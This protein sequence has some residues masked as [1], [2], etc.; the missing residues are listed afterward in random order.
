MR[1]PTFLFAALCGLF[2]SAGCNAD[3][4]Y[5]PE[6]IGQEGRVTV[7]IDSSQWSAEVGEALRD[8]LGSDIATLPAP[9]PAFDLRQA[10]I[11]SPDQFEELQKFKNIIFVG[12][13]SD[14]TRE[15]QFLRSVFSPEAQTAIQDGNTALVGRR[16]V[17]R[18]RQQVFYLTADTPSALANAIREDG[19]AI[20]DTFE[21]VTRERLYREMFERGRQPDLEEQ[22]MEQY[23]FAVNVQHDY[24]IALDT[25]RFVWLRRVLPDTWRS[26]AVYYEE[27][28]DPATITPEWIYATRDSLTRLYMQGSVAGWINIDYRRPLETERTDFLG[29]YAFETR[30]LWHLIGEEDGE[31]VQ[32]GMGGPFLTYTFYD[33]PSGRIYMIDGMVFAPGFDKREFLRQLEVI[34][35]TFRSGPPGDQLA[36]R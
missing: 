12:A 22:L 35:H 23:G 15:A 8:V 2:V 1:F 28:A 4:D 6:A 3:A 21:V 14:S 27:N 9:E 5:R 33:Q 25:T 19:S 24:Q 29:H 20:R 10:S 11:R 16:D 32:Y 26:L 18:R 17:W 13:L 30:G 36:S 31:E 7:V 34:A